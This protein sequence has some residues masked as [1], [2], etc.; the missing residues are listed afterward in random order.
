MLLSQPG[1]SLL[2]VDA[3]AP[4][5][6][7]VELDCCADIGVLAVRE[8]AVLPAVDEVVECSPFDAPPQNGPRGSTD[9]EGLD[10]WDGEDYLETPEEGK[11]Y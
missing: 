2:P 10:M 3:A 4:Q 9:S 6:R 11:I 8:G 1:A 5:Q 7:V